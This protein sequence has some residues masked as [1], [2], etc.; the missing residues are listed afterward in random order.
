M[1]W[2]DLQLMAQ[3]KGGSVLSRSTYAWWGAFLSRNENVT[4]PT[5]WF[6]PRLSYIDTSLL[7]VPGWREVPC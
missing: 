7:V 3:C 1:D 6:G 5:P 2:V 4:M